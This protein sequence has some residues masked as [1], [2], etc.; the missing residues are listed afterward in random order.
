MERAIRFL[1]GVLDMIGSSVLWE[2]IDQAIDAC[3]PR[4]GGSPA[5]A[6]AEETPENASL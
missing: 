5:M 3:L 1:L 2:D 4:Q 6:R